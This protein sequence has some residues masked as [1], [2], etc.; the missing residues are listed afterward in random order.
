[1]ELLHPLPPHHHDPPL[2][3][4]ALHRYSPPPSTS[5][6]VEF[7]ALA[8]PPEAAAEE[9]KVHVAVGKSVGKGATLLQWAF[10]NFTNPHIL[11]LHVHQP[12]PFIPTL[13]GK[14]PASQANPEVVSAF[15]REE[16]EQAMRL[17]DNYLRIC[18]AAKVKASFM[19]TEA[20]QVQKGIVD[21]VVGHN[22]RRLVIGAIPEGWMKVKRNSRKAN[23]AA[24]NAPPFCKI[25]FIY[26]GKHIW[27]REASEKPCS[28]SPCET[29]ETE[30]T[31][32]AESTTSSG[33]L[34]QNSAESSSDTHLE[35]EEERVNSQLVEVK[36]EADEAADE[37]FVE[38]LKLEAEATE[39]IR[40]VNLFES[41]HAQEVKLRQEAEDELRTTVKDQ[42]KLLDENE[43]I[44]SE[45]QRTMRSI[46]ILN[47]CV[48]E[49]DHRRDAAEDELSLIQASISTLWHEK[50]QIRRQKMEAIRWLDRWKSR[51]Q[52]GVAHC[53]GVVGFAEELPE[54]A[55]FSLLD[56]Q[57]ATC[58]FS[59]SFKIKE[60][61]YGAIYKGEML[62]RTVAVRK[63]HS[64]NLQAPSQFHQEVQVLG[65]FQH[66]HLLTLL[67]VCPEAWSLVYEYLPN[68]SIQ[69]SLLRRSNISPLT[70]NI[71][72]RWIAEIAS[73]IC[74]LHSSKPETIIHG[75]LNLD[76]ILLDSALSCKIC[77]FGFS[78]LVTEDS[79]YLPSFGLETEPRGSFTY[80]DPEFQRTGLTPKSDIYS[81][82]LIILQLLT[83]RTPVGLVGEVQKAVTYGRLSSILD[84]SVGEWPLAVATRLADLGL[85]CC[86]QY[87]RDR[88]ELTPSLVRELEQLH[89]SEERPVPSFFLCPILQEI[90]HDPQVAA[91]GFTYERDAITEWL[92]NGHETS[93]MT[94]LKLN[95]L[96]LTPNHALRLAIQEWL[97]KP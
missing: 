54:I 18:R 1:M 78:R 53:N 96:Y 38:L 69:D 52:V 63:L 10:S 49:T 35:A 79:L 68:G 93:P 91:D 73:A 66:P 9:D 29:I 75:D 12:S 85:Q 42:Q 89:V 37:S 64:H 60:G 82:G 20:D 7:H 23:Y 86:Q 2:A 97:C 4:D 80:T 26:R 5:S 17:L 47:S 21:L 51:G 92:E 94:N 19:M 43:E 6:R 57:N 71:R 16:K 30:G 90:M 55:E 95:H 36:Q 28:L 70:W 44:G 13:L 50:Q 45:L 67:G 14:L 22:I 58:N 33:P 84:S 8:T 34:P 39:A 65:S 31:F 56:I 74:F 62:G 32:A 11:L 59:E 77:E 48:Q 15:R 83:G 76:I 46:A 3:A 72:T 61:G 27:T 87:S 81:F 40:K 88:P 25:W 41:A 24:K